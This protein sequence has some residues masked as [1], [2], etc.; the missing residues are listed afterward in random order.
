MNRWKSLVLSVTVALAWITGCATSKNEEQCDESVC[1]SPANYVCSS[2]VAV[3]SVTVTARKDYASYVARVTQDQS[4]SIREGRI[5]IKTGAK[6]TEEVEARQSAKVVITTVDD[7]FT[8]TF[9]RNKDCKT[10]A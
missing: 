5:L 7:S 8:R 10:S 6:F 2:P 1:V 9:D 4:E 3:M